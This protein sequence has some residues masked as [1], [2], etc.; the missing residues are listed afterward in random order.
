MIDFIGVYPNAAPDDYCDRM[1]AKFD[2]LEKTTAGD[3]GE[4]RNGGVRMRKDVAFSFQRDAPEL[5]KETNRI[6]DRALALYLDEH[7]A[8]DMTKFYSHAVKVQ[9]TKPKGG[10]HKWHSER[11]NTDTTRVLVWMIYL[12]TCNGDEGTTEFIEQGK[13]LSAE[14][15]TVVFFP[16]DWTHTHR[17]NPVYTCDKYITTGWYYL[18]E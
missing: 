5:A 4:E 13:K 10:F 17:G 1:I 9:K 3:R 16:A 14:K 12:N 2:E 15:G 6:L 7:P 11:N 8:L 18:S